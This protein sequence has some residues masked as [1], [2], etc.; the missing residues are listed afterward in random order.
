MND[1]ILI[2]VALSVILA[3]VAGTAIQI[4]KPQPTPILVME[5]MRRPDRP[6]PR[7]DPMTV[8]SD[9]V[10]KSFR[11]RITRPTVVNFWASWC[12]PCIRE[13]PLFAKFKPMAE[14]AG[15]NVLTVNVD[16]EGAPVA[17]KFLKDHG[18]EG[19]PV[20]LDR[21]TSVSKALEVKGMPTALLINTKGEE[22]ARMEGEA[23]W[24]TTNAVDVVATLMDL[25]AVPPD[26]K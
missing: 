11:E 1:R 25:K 13:L 9:G 16:K 3:M 18:I 21:D 14:A 8:D 23:D 26:A 7:A 15:I 5:S 17:L 20:I 10:A 22:V 6:I 4:R 2:L 24:S 12:V 19:L